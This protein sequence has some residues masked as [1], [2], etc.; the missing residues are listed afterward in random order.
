MKPLIRRVIAG[1]VAIAAIAGAFL[2][3][4]V[5]GIESDPYGDFP[6]GTLIAA[7]TQ[8]RTALGMS[9]GWSK[10]NADLTDQIRRACP[11][12]A[13]VV[14]TGGQSNASNAISTPFDADPA[15]PVF[16]FFD[17]HCFAL[18]D[19]LLGTTGTRGSVWSRLG[20]ALAA[21]TGRPVV[22]VNGAIGG[23]QF[24]DWTDKRSPY[25]ANL[26]RRVADA[27]KQLGPADIVLWHQGE[28]DAW[29]TT[30]Q[31]EIQ[32]E[33]KQVTDT[34]LTSFA[35]KPAAK[36]VLY[37]ASLCTGA[38]R[39]T[40][41]QPLLAAQTAVAAANPRIVLG[42]DTDRFGRRF[43]H[44]DCHFND[45]GARSMADATLALIAP[46]LGAR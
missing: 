35:L 17:G 27:A 24:S 1:T 18:R 5:Y 39:R 4:T 16:M 21:R 36:L 8:V 15:A 19:P 25:M 32:P 22:F 31:A 9:K 33:I 28:T 44:D 26:R 29:F 6:A 38:R 2:A 23:S 14:V 40:S 34:V 37:R 7:K 46:M 30:S 12:N 10:S 3:G 41:N 43:R 45:A 11:A 13:L 42:P 20:P